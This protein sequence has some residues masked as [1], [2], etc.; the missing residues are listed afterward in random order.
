MELNVSLI[1]GFQMEARNEQGKIAVMDGSKT[2]G[3]QEDG[4]R[5]MEMI[6]SGLA[7]CSGID[8]LS[9]LKKARQPVEKFHINVKAERADAIPAVFTKIHLHFQSNAGVSL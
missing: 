6:L 9:I 3:G 4:M 5:P 2:I 1:S 7:G 8:V